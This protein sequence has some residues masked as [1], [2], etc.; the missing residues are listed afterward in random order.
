MSERSLE[1][2]RAVLAA[3]G[4][5]A[6]PGPERIREIIDNVK[7]IAVVGLSRDPSKP[8]RSVPAYLAS[9]GY[10]LIPVNP[11]A[12]RI[13][14]KKSR[15]SLDKVEEPVDAV[16]VFRPSEE[17]GEHVRAAAAREEAPV[18]WLQQG[19]RSDDAAAAARAAGRTVVQDL[20]MYRAHD[21]LHGDDSG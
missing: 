20:C 1:P 2:L 17:A 5:P 14:G 3:S 11:H 21:A 19:I 7:T 9:H 6:N 8:A 10:E 18:I 13:L 12:D 4:D 16:L 15:D